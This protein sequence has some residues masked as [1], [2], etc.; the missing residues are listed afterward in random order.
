MHERT[1]QELYHAIA[2]AKSIDEEADEKIPEQ[3]QIEQTGIAQ[4][5]FDIFPSVIS[6]ENEEMSY[7]F[8]DICFDVL[9][10]FQKAFGPLPSQNDMVLTGWKNR[11]Y[12]WTLNYNH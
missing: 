9:F 10:V 8:I 2:Y 4:A 7:L 5:I 3:F 12:S 11:Q 1:T 6:E